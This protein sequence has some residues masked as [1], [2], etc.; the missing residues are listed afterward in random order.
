MELEIEETKVSYPNNI[1]ISIEENIKLILEA[2]NKYIEKLEKEAETENCVICLDNIQ[3]NKSYKLP[4]CGHEFHQ[5]CIMH[6]FREG[7]KKCPLCNN[8]G[9]SNT[10]APGPCYFNRFSY[11]HFK[12]LRKLS[13][14]KNAPKDLKKFMDKIKKKE[15][16]L[17]KLNK[18]IKIFKN[19]IHT[20]TYK[21]LT[22][23][24]NKLN[25]KKWRL[26]R[27]L[28]RKKQEICDL[29]NIVPLIIV[30]KK[31]ID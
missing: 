9:A 23:K 11:S 27:T 10:P 19:K 24:F 25:S 29:I 20:D 8:L 12:R 4:E 14:K 6:W 31:I 13:K 26:G 17:K 5:N 15:D 2:N 7:N 16:K 21:N 3:C 28:G 1:P 30:E 18:E 22:N